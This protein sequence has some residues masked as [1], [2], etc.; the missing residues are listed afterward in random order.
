MHILWSEAKADEIIQRF[1]HTLE[2]GEPCV[3]PEQIEERIDRAGIEYY[4]GQINRI[5]LPHGR[6]G[7]VCYFRD[8]SERVQAQIKIRESEER[9]RNLFNSM[10]EGFCVL[11]MIFDAHQKPV[12]W[13]FLEA[14]PS[15]ER[16]TGML[17]I[18][19]KRVRELLPDHEA[20][21]FETY[22][23]VALTGEPV[24]FVNEAKEL[25]GRWFD[26]YAF[27]VGGPGSYKV[28]VIFTNISERKQA[29][30]ALRQSEARFRAL[31][32]RGPIAMYSCDSAGVIQEFNRSAVKLWGREPKQGNTDEQFRGL[33]KF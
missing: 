9:Y 20:Y 24:R 10:D 2:T 5:L 7:V 33:F 19:G 21:W 30:Q 11:E 8:I 29:E 4:E 28:A 18:V 17:D 32:D 6:H 1:R 26:L 25:E 3:V 13:R 22:G 27:R 16:H 23:K 15:F 31:F 12:D 14:N